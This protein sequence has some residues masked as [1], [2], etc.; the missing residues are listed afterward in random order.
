METALKETVE[1]GRGHKVVEIFTTN[2]TNE[3]LSRYVVVQLNNFI[4]GARVNF[5]LDDCDKI[6]RIESVTSINTSAVMSIVEGMGIEINL[7][8]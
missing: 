3:S 6:L 2:V 7:L 4:P 1:S 5:D 8:D